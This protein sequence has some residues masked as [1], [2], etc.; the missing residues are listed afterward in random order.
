LAKSA[1][2]DLG[3]GQAAAFQATSQAD[4][5]L[6]MPALTAAARHDISPAFTFSCN[7]GALRASA[8]SFC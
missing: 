3:G 1:G 4:G 8:S 2:N 6:M 7:S 5:T